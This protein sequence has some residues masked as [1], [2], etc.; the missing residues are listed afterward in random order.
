VPDVHQSAPIAVDAMG[1]DLAP[2]PVVEG[3]LACARRCGVA[4]QLVGP[5]D[6]LEPLLSARPDFAD[7]PVAIVPATEAVE[8]CEAPAA[9]L[10]R[11]PDAS[12]RVAMQQVA[13]G[14]ARAVVSAGNTGATVMAARTTLGLVAGVDR[15]ALAATIPTSCGRA[16]LLDAGANAECR[17]AH[18][19]QFGVMGAVFA[20]IALD[21][22]QPRVGLLS[23]GEEE[24][25]GNELTREAHRLLKAAPVR[26]VG[27]VEARDVYAG[28]ADVIVCDGFT[29]NIALKISESLVDLIAREAGGTLADD[30]RR[31]L[32]SAEHGGALLLG[33]GGVVIVGHG[34]SSAGAIENAIA[35]AGRFASQGLVERLERG[36]A[37]IPVSAS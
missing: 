30:L 12:I 37:A 19:V 24:G 27:N 10:R 33:V 2:G 23:I 9:A 32:D 20:Q 6:R 7:L 25:K 13:M 31:R 18:L 16:V 36:I 17:P 35:L 11:K 26:F 14:R 21:L 5:A 28:V 15:P 1:G 22:E 3:A 4:I 34:R 29:G 8:M